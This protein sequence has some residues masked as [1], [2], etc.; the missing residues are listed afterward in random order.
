M[1]VNGVFL[2]GHV[3]YG[4]QKF[5]PCWDEYKYFTFLRKSIYHFTSYYKDSS[6]WSEIISKKECISFERNNKEGKF[7]QRKI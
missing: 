2:N 5:M 6:R 3:S 7:G 4:I 1:G